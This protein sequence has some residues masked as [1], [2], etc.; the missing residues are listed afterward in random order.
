MN[1][2]LVIGANGSVGRASLEALG[3]EN[4]VAITRRNWPEHSPFAHIQLHSDG[5]L[6]DQAF[7][8][9]CA[10]INAAGRV[11]AD[12]AELQ[13]ANVELPVKLA[14]QARD[15]GISK[16]VQ[17]SSF[18]I[19]GLAEYICHETE[20]MPITAYGR[21][22]QVGDREL[23]ALAT[24]AFAVE[25]VRLPFLFDI[26]N[27]ALVG[28]LVKAALKSPFWPIADE[29]QGRS[30]I[31]YRDAG[32][33]LAH[34]ASSSRSCI[35]HA[36]DPQLFTFPLLAEAMKRETGHQL[37]LIKLP[38]PLIAIVAAAAPGLHRRLFR[39]SIL[40]EEDNIAANLQLPIGL[41][42]AI[43]F[44]IRKGGHKGID[45]E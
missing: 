10:I 14:R 27:P 23:L 33:V 44:I 9:V 19:Y 6:P 28:S 2:V 35:T 21:S 42:K 5:S 25:C 12:E 3:S 1:K 4:G 26:D 22:K 32:T 15:C 20:E 36:A 37:R 30:M 39:S 34:S 31:S 29:S 8:G 41:E 13:A 40:K 18:S 38:A 16:F 24:D 43:S 17:V 45:R 11:D 7:D